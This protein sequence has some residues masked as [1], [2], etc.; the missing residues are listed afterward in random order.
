MGVE[1]AVMVTEE[2]V[3]DPDADAVWDIIELFRQWVVGVEAGVIVMVAEGD[4]A[5]VMVVEEADPDVDAVIP[6]FR[7]V[8]ELVCKISGEVNTVTVVGR[9]DSFHIVC[10]MVQ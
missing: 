5:A 7:G 9:L 1:A 4:E 8:K 3:P 10:L 2:A 6:V